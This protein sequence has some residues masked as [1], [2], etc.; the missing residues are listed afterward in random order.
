MNGPEG[1]APAHQSS[2][3]GFR[4]IISVCDEWRGNECNLANQ[5]CF[6]KGEM[7]EMQ[8]IIHFVSMYAA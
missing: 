6:N 7:Q 8:C 2:R 3:F 5:E 4:F 1:T